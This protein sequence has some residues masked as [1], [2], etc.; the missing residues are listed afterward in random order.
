VAS[1]IRPRAAAA[2]A[3]LMGASLMGIGA[4]GI[5]LYSYRPAGGEGP[6]F[7]IE[8]FIPWDGS[9]ATSY[10]EILSEE[11]GAEFLQTSFSP[12]RKGVSAKGLRALVLV[13][14]DWTDAEKPP[15]LSVR[16]AAGKTLYFPEKMEP[17]AAEPSPRGTGGISAEA[18]RMQAPAAASFDRPSVAPGGIAFLE[19][20]YSNGSGARGV[21][22]PAPRIVAGG[23]EAGAP[24]RVF[25]DKGE[26]I[27]RYPFRAGASGRLEISALGKLLSIP[28][29]SFP[30][31]EAAGEKPNASL[32]SGTPG[33][34][35]ALAAIA[36][37]LSIIAVALTIL[38]A[39]RFGK[40]GPLA[41]ATGFAAAAALL[42]ASAF[43]A[44]IAP[45]M[46]GRKGLDGESVPRAIA[47]TA[48]YPAPERGSRAFALSG[49]EGEGKLVFLIGN[50]S[51]EVWMLVEYEDGSRGWM[52][53][54]GSAP[55]AVIFPGR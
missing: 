26:L 52:P 29:K 30:I 9:G 11:K 20:R 6:G 7:E 21:P 51:G 16:F 25:G 13:S 22:D 32:P 27:L 28:V 2:I 3:L 44:F 50:D 18:P 34:W 54:D 12:G 8:L 35:P 45:R 17:P 48:L 38:L 41:A 46:R 24:T 15:R 31:G 53:R 40:R 1:T 36:L 14:G 43:F 4:Q 37:V 23:A 10:P 49:T 47:G 42:I 55:G 19:I 33:H 39:L 5:E